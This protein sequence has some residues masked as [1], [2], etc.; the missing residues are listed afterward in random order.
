MGAVDEPGAWREEV[1][2]V[3][4][5]TNSGGVGV[6]GIRDARVAAWVKAW[7]LLRNEG[8]VSGED[9]DDVMR[10]ADELGVELSWTSFTAEGIYD[11][12]F[13]PR[14]VKTDAKA[15]EPRSFYRRYAVAPALA[16]KSRRPRP[17]TPRSP[18]R[19][20]A[21][22]HGARRRNGARR[23]ASERQRKGGSQ[24]SAP[25][26]AG[27]TGPRR[28]TFPRPR[29]RAACSRTCGPR[30]WASKGSAKKTTSSCWAATRSWRRRS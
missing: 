21:R 14:R 5:E 15:E 3:L 17:R 30:C 9:P 2:T 1:K 6:E 10:F 29:R 25:S 22:L 13:R 16:G 26:P 20:P 23:M 18:A 28:F 12:V 24:G 4:A 8:G 7:Q 19:T 11:A 27:P